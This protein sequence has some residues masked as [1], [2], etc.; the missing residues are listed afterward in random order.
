MTLIC[1]KPLPFVPFP[2]V[3]SRR[4]MVVYVDVESLVS[5]MWR[6]AITVNPKP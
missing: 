4:L 3:L 6:G 2:L 5:H 1:P